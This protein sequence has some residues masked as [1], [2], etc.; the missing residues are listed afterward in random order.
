MSVMARMFNMMRTKG[1][2]K[3]EL[4]A[5]GEL[6]LQRTFPM[7][8]RPAADVLA[9]ERFETHEAL[10]EAREQFEPGMKVIFVTQTWLSSTHNDNSKNEKCQLLQRVLRR[11]AAGESSVMVR[12]EI[13]ASNGLPKENLRKIL[14]NGLLF[15]VPVL[16]ILSLKCLE[17]LVLGKV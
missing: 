8:L 17:G 14:Q 7:Y 4:S 16:V 6:A 13:V 11:A 2:K 9:L 12:F 15:I 10:R 5:A 1:E 3:K